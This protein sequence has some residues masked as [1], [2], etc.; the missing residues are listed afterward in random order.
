MPVDKMKD[1]GLVFGDWTILETLGK[2]K[3]LCRC[4]CGTERVLYKKSLVSGVT[5]SCGC[6]RKENFR[7]SAIDDLTGARFGAWVVTKELGNGYVECRCDCGTIRKIHKPSLKSG[8]TT[9]CGCLSR[10][11][12]A[13]TNI[14]N[15]SLVGKTFNDLTIIEELGGGLVKCRCSCGNEYIGRKQ[16]IKSGHTKSC[17]CKTYSFD[18]RARDRVGEK[19]GEWEIIEELGNN[20][21]RCRCSCGTERILRKDIIVQGKSKSCGCKST[22][23]SRQTMLEKY[24]ELSIHKVDSPREAWQIEVVSSQESFKNFILEN[25]TCKPTI[26]MLAGDLGLGEASIGRKIASYGLYDYISKAISTSFYEIELYKYVK[27]LVKNDYDIINRARNILNGKE[28]D[29]YI[30]SKKLA[31]EFNGAY[32]HSSIFKEYKY[33]QNKT[34]ECAKNGIRLI[35]VFEYEWVNKDKKNKIKAYLKDILCKD[36]NTKIYGRNTV[37]NEINAD[38]ARGFIN[39]NHLQG[40]INSSINIGCFYNNEL[41]GVMALGKARFDTHNEYEIYR[42]CFKHGVNVI[43]GA[44]K[45]FKYFVDTYKPKSVVTYSDISKFTGNVYPTM[46]F[47]VV[48]ITSPN[49][50]WVNGH[51]LEVL[52][53]EMTQKHKLVEA[54]LGTPEQ[55]ED[56]IMYSLGYYK[57]YDSG[58]IKLEI[59]V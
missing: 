27:E 42:M 36:E 53:R 44:N 21:V 38:E 31:I 18:Y 11:K 35:H 48:K 5:K 12:A 13:S 16:S 29:I 49:Y 33:H 46:G 3:V 22:E 1:V 8:A 57:V 2:G 28:L 10:A 32:W 20:R 58:N 55:T 15:H 37:I 54:N 4:S 23:M 50:V 47:K 56:E 14:E 26:K 6:K 51:T 34:I 59:E 41:V 40:Y 30:P 17:G 7:K 52:S 25:Y 39:T 24:G 43:G 19:Y 9:S 45:L